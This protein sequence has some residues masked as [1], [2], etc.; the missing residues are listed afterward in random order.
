MEVFVTEMIPW[1]EC[2]STWEGLYKCDVQP[3]S[4][5]INSDTIVGLHQLWFINTLVLPIILLLFLLI[6]GYRFFVKK[7]IIYLIKILEK[8]YLKLLC[9]YS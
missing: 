4:N 5:I 8:K 9:G 7:K 3:Q 6:A 1:A 2:V